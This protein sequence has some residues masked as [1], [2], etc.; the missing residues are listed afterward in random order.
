MVNGAL[1]WPGTDTTDGKGHVLRF[2]LADKKFS[3]IKSP[4]ASSYNLMVSQGNKLCAHRT[5]SLHQEIEMWVL[6]EQD[7]EITEPK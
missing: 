6:E 2:H 1:N 4:F 5:I 3:F 7:Q